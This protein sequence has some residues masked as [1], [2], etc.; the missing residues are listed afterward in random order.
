MCAEHVRA[1]TE[2]NRTG[3]EHDRAGAEHDRA[4]TEHDRAGTEHDR[5]DTEH[6]G[7]GAGLL[8]ATHRDVMQ[9]ALPV[10]VA[11]LQVSGATLVLLLPAL[12]V[13]VRLVTTVTATQART[14]T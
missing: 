9:F 10:V 3:T 1:G 11:E 8:V 14:N 5:A 13:V 12:A 6:D 4:G 7:A 2:H